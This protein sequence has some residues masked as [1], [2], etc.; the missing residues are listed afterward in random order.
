L[1]DLVAR[2]D[3]PQLNDLD[4]FYFNQLIFDTPQFIQF[5]SRTATLKALEQAHVVFDGGYCA[6]VEL[7]SQTSG[8]G[9]LKVCIGCTQ[10]DW[11]AS[12][13]GQV[14]SSVLPPLYTVEHLYVHKPQHLRLDWEDDIEI[15]QWLELLHPF[16]AAKHLYLSKEFAPGIAAA[17]QELVGERVTEVLPA[18]QS[19]HLALE[20]NRPQHVQDVVGQFLAAR[21]LSGHPIAILH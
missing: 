12:S 7:S 5:I 6:W 1:E 8:Y 21:Q 15:S 14:C 4:I 10:L 9:H 13:L 20:W 17:L 16:M 11:Q 3:A 19:L 2:F 18:L